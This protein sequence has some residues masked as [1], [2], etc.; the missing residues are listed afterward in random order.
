[1][2]N[3]SIDAIIVGGGSG[4]RLGAAAPKAFIPLAGKPLFLYSLEQFNAHESIGTIIFVVPEPVVEQTKKIVPVPRK[5]LLIVAGGAERWMSVRNGVGHSKAEWV[6]V[7]DVARPLVTRAVIDALLDTSK[8]YE[9]AVTATPVV[10]TIRT[11]DGADR[12]LGTVDRSTLLRVGTPQLFKRQALMAAFDKAPLLDKP[13]TDEAVL[14]ELSGIAV[15]WA[16]GDPMNFKIT[17]QQDLEL[18]EAIVAY[19]KK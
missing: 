6:L 12:T 2:T 13:P 18:A 16:P 11:F 15:G 5:P 14:M 10:D 17:T 7:H 19:R 3:P 9:C 1:M 4:T 8:K